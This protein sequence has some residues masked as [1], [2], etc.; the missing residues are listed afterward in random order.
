MPLM[1]A[2]DEATVEAIRRA[3]AERGELA[4]VAELR[5]RFPGIEALAQAREMV[6]LI[7]R[8]QPPG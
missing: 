4:A 1:F 7:A 3:F 8:W 6:R 5:R 2:V